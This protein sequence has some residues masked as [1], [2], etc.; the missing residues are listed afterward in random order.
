LPF[1]GRRK[2]AHRQGDTRPSQHMPLVE[3]DLPC[4]VRVFRPVR[5]ATMHCCHRHRPG[6]L[7]ASIYNRCWRVPGDDLAHSANG[8]NPELR[9]NRKPGAEANRVP[10]RRPTFDAWVDQRSDFRRMNS[11][12]NSVRR[13][14]NPRRACDRPRPIFGVHRQPL[15][16]LCT[17]AV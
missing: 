15:I 9:S 7:D 2:Q 13:G 10:V 12:E 8:N 1:H 6:R 4:V 16:V 14:A 3:G 5:F 11:L 17:K